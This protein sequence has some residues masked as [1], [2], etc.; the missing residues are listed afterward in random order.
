MQWWLHFN[1]LKC[2]FLY[3]CHAHLTYSTPLSLSP[4][5]FLYLQLCP[6]FRF[7]LFPPLSPCCSLGLMLVFTDVKWEKQTNLQWCLNMKV[8]LHCYCYTVMLLHYCCVVIYRY[9][10]I[11]LLC[12]LADIYIFRKNL[13]RQLRIQI[14]LPL[15]VYEVVYERLNTRR[16]QASYTSMNLLV[17]KFVHARSQRCT[18]G[19]PKLVHP[20]VEVSSRPLVY[21][22]GHATSPAL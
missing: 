12:L 17:Y 10:V 4:S 6:T 15:T 5:L 1:R 19:V 16:S 9:V 14:H 3:V 2:K 18:L 22:A 20:F 7:P 13:H 11:L 21:K 8:V